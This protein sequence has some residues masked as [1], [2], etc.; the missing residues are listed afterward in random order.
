M[1]SQVGARRFDQLVCR[2]KATRR[3]ALAALIASPLQWVERNARASTNSS[4]TYQDIWLGTCREGKTQSPIL[5]DDTKLVDTIGG[6]TSIDFSGI[7]EHIKNATVI[8]NSHGSPQINV[9]EGS[10]NVVL[11]GER[12]DLVQ[13]HFHSPSEHVI[14]NVRFPMEAHLVF[15]SHENSTRPLVIALLL[16]NGDTKNVIL[17]EALHKAPFV[18]KEGVPLDNPI[19][20]KSLLV[21]KT[22]MQR[23]SSEFFYL[24]PG[25]LTTPPCSE[26]VV[27]LV[28]HPISAQTESITS[29]QLHR[30]LSLSEIPGNARDIQPENERSIMKIY[31][32]Y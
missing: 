16:H 20:L 21:Q 32:K 9:P 2:A 3:G 6:E 22:T 8:N 28:K 4:W 14:N 30:F 24:Y 12:F 18:A 13:I 15:K 5:I 17:E 27:W 19:P 10:C 11:G 29:D 25:S 1:I 26:P 23:G 7:P 31:V